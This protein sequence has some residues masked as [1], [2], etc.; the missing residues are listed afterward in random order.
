MYGR[1]D[2]HTEITPCVQQDIVLFRSAAQ[3][4]KDHIAMLSCEDSLI[5][6]LESIEEDNKEENEDEE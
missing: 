4:N 3:K 2:G 1:M 5:C 6:E